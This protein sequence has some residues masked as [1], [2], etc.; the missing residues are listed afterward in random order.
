MAHKLLKWEKLNCTSAL[1]LQFAPT[2]RYCTPLNVL[3]FFTLILSFPSYYKQHPLLSVSVSSL[4]PKITFGFRFSSFVSLLSTSPRLIP[5][6]LSIH[7]SI[8]LTC[9]TDSRG[10]EEREISADQFPKF[11]NLFSL[12]SLVIRE[13]LQRRMMGNYAGLE[14]CFTNLASPSLFISHS[15]LLCFSDFSLRVSH[16]LRLLFI[17]HKSFSLLLAFSPSLS[18]GL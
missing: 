4:H 8:L 2:W 18:Q 9:C 1:F 14:I 17:F 5:P 3:H 12:K 7:P 15:F 6:S 10:A 16:Y 11:L 13:V